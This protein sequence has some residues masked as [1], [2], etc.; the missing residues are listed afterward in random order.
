MVVWADANRYQVENN[1]DRAEECKKKVEADQRARN[2]ARKQSGE[3]YV[4]KMFVKGENGVWTFKDAGP[5]KGKG[6][7][8]LSDDS[9]DDDTPFIKYANGFFFF[10]SFSSSSFKFIPLIHCHPGNLNARSLLLFNCHLLVQVVA[11]LQVLRRHRLPEARLH[12][13]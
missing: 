13:H 5:Y 1:E 9:D 2:E 3:E 12:H 8:R 4:P 7:D 11:V 6:A 10:F